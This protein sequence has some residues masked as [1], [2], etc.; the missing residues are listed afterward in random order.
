MEELEARHQALASRTG[1]IPH[2][3]PRD[4]LCCEESWSEW[5]DLNLRPS[6]RMREKGVRV[7]AKSLLRF[8]AS[9]STRTLRKYLI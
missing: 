5:Q 9:V 2:I 6:S 7:E 3:V 8:K 4:G 1:I